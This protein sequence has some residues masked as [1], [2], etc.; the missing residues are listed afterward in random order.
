MHTMSSGSKMD[1]SK[2]LCSLS[3]STKSILVQPNKLI[4]TLL[5]PTTISTT[6]NKTDVDLL[7]VS[8]LKRDTR[9][10][11]PATILK[12]AYTHIPCWKLC[13]ILPSFEHVCVSDI[14][15]T[16]VFVRFRIQKKNS[17]NRSD[18]VIGIVG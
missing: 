5:V 14:N 7:I 15:A 18:I 2:A 8:L 1:R 13:I 16:K 4:C 11:A 10:Y 12:N 17:S 6:K 3:R 9:D